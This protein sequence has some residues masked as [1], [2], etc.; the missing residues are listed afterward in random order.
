[1]KFSGRRFAIGTGL[2]AVALGALGLWLWTPDKSRAELEARYATAPTD[3]VEAA[4]VRLHVRDTGPRGAPA[5]IL[6]HGFGASLHTWEP[7]AAQLSEHLR[8]I[9]YDLTGAG[10]TGVDPTGDYTDE[11]AMQLLLA[12]MDRLGIARA[13]IVGHSMGGRVAWR[14]AAEHPERVDRLVLV[15]PDGFAS[16]GFEYDRKPDV[17]AVMELM[18]YVLPKALLRM[19]L[20]PAYADPEK[21]S[22][23]VVTR[24]HDLMVAPGVRG[25]LLERLRQ[26]VRRDPVAKLA[27]IQAPVLLVWGEKDAVIPVTNAADYRKALKRSTLVTFPGVGHIPQ[28]E[29]PVESL[30]AV[31]AF[32]LQ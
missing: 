20:A 5:V 29:A 2:I 15:A 10:L 11:R 22:D 8:V 31:R 23:D 27:A 12:L 28:E 6:L 26:V 17:P 30:P 13:S 16:P 25:A 3:F 32:L 9:R 4:G 24:Y 1:L 14:F 19:N 7:W 18:R 21:L